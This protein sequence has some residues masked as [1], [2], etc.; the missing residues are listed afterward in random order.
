[1]NE[2]NTVDITTAEQLIHGMFDETFKLGLPAQRIMIHGTMGVGKS[3]IVHSYPKEINGKPVRCHVLNGSAIEP[4]DVGG[5]GVPDHETRKLYFNTPEWWP[6]D[7]DEYF[8]LFLDEINNTSKAVMHSFYRL[9]LDG[10]IQNGKKLPK[11][12]III[13][14]GN[15]VEDGTGAK[16]LL[17]ALANRFTVHLFIDKDTTSTSF[18]RWASNNNISR[19]IIAYI[20]ANRNAITSTANGSGFARPRTWEA[21]D[22]HLRSP[23]SEHLKK[24]RVAGAI[25]SD[26]ATGFY[27]FLEFKE[28]MPD[29]DAIRSGQ[30]VDISDAQEAQF[31]V[32]I[33]GAYEVISCSG[34][35]QDNLI[36]YL[37]QL[38]DECLVAM[39]QTIKIDPTKFS[40]MVSSA[41]LMK[42]FGKVKH[43]VVV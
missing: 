22:Q 11:N 18:L 4:P 17:P 5:L 28:F 14:A 36:D 34:E 1:M 6:E 2:L 9:V 41:K 16:P 37:S 15:M 33:H 29:W 25:G 20:S 21:V 27:S 19:D 10:T 39:F 26:Q 3:S 35:E 40:K 32:A 30:S 12:T 31:I 24:I 13:A 42:L 7:D 38:E 23:M 8:I 43:R